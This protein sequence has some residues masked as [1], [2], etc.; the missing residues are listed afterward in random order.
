VSEPLT[1]VAAV[2]GGMQVSRDGAKVPIT[3]EEIAE[4]ARLCREARQTAIDD[5]L[6]DGQ[7]HPASATGTTLVR[8]AHRVHKVPVGYLAWLMSV[9]PK[10][11]VFESSNAP[12][13][14]YVVVVISAQDGRLLGDTAGYAP[15][16][17]GHSG[18]SWAEGEWTGGRP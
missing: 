10:A 14:N 16:L 3:P 7:R 6:R 13:A 18:P 11:P 4:E 9:R 1:I 5:A 12:A 17:D 2:N 8:I 15:V